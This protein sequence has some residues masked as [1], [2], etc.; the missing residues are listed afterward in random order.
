MKSKPRYR[1]ISWVAERYSVHPQT[2]RLWEREGLL[3]PARSRGNTRLYDEVTCD[4][5]ETVIALTRDLGVNLAGVEIILNLREQVQKLQKD[6]EIL[7]DLVR[8]HLSSESEVP[9]YHA[10]V[11]VESGTIQV[12]EDDS[13]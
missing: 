5:L 6:N 13:V 2:L 8:H 9:R 7:A 10:L 4:R 12:V 3:S 11:R 1:M